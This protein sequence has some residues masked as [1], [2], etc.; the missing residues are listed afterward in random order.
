MAGS[1]ERVLKIS[2]FC[3]IFNKNSHI[4]LI[5]FLNSLSPPLYHFQ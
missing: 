1:V 3:S 4:L 5:H 2:L